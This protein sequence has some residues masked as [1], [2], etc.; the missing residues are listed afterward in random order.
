MNWMKKMIMKDTDREEVLKELVDLLNKHMNDEIPM[1]NQYVVG[2]YRVKDD[3]LLGYHLSTACQLTE[4][5]LE[6]KRYEDIDDNPYP[7]LEIISMNLKYTLDSSEEEPGFMGFANATRE[8]YFEGYV[9]GEI[10]LKAIY[11]SDGTPKKSVIYT[12]K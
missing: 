12:Y 2:Y 8:Q 1:E 9:Q 7:Q 4:E 3:K 5:I 11:L 10:Y 6:G